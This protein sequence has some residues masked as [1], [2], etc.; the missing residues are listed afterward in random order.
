MSMREA[1]ICIFRRTYVSHHVNFYERETQRNNTHVRA[2]L[3]QKFMCFYV[4][5][6]RDVYLGER[7]TYMF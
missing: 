4:R 6:E 3:L 5:V 7:R 1:H 2:S